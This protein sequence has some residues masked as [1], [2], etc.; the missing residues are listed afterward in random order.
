MSVQNHFS[1]NMSAEA[2]YK[3]DPVMST[4]RS[5]NG[6]FLIIIVGLYILSWMLI[7]FNSR[8]AILAMNLYIPNLCHWDKR[9]GKTNHRN[10]THLNQIFCAINYLYKK[11][12]T[13]YNTFNYIAILI[14][15]HLI[16]SF[17]TCYVNLPVC[18]P[19]MQCII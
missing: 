12:K 7:L 10:P 17:I 16:H 15:V 9:D 18:L 1:G 8:N 2:S 4:R 3:Y 5:E 13:L 11:T 19:V 14:Y 6:Q